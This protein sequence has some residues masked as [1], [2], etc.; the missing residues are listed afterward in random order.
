MRKRVRN[1]RVCLCNGF[2]MDAKKPCW[3]DGLFMSSGDTRT[4]FSS[5]RAASAICKRDELGQRSGNIGIAA[6]EESWLVGVAILTAM[7]S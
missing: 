7:Q 6:A 5:R 1:Q 4:Y 2:V 3:V